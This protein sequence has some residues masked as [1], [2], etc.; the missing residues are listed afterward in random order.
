MEDTKLFTQEYNAEFRRV[1][2]FK[3]GSTSP[4]QKEL[5]VKFAE[6]ASVFGFPLNFIRPQTNTE[7]ESLYPVVIF[8]RKMSD[9]T[10]IGYN[11]IAWETWDTYETDK[12]EEVTQVDTT[13]LEPDISEGISAELVKGS[14]DKPLED[15]P[16]MENLP[17][18]ER[19][20][21]P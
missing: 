9:P 6:V 1:N 16:N 5:A 3:F 15:A 2:R 11:V 7:G 20:D 8:S 12:M 10:D 17:G 14:P 19:Q 13:T 18:Q 21:I 4:D